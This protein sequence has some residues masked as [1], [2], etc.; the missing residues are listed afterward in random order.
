MY[1]KK[2]LKHLQTLNLI[3]PSRLIPFFSSL[4]HHRDEW[5][6]RTKI[7]HGNSIPS[8]FRA[9]VGAVTIYINVMICGAQKV[10]IAK[11]IN[12]PLIS[13]GFMLGIWFNFHT[14]A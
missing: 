11:L 13:L 8:D 3:L 12:I 9:G 14:Y 2:Q 10:E 7:S 4:I 6:H 5:L 1:S